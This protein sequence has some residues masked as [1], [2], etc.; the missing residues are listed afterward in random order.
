MKKHEETSETLSKITDKFQDKRGLA[1][2]CGP[3][4]PIRAVPQL[5]KLKNASLE[6]DK[7]SI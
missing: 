7:D 4:I 6:K 2:T 5:I 3:I 1:R